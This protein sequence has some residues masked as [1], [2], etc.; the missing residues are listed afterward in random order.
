[1]HPESIPFGLRKKNITLPHKKIFFV[2]T[3][4]LKK[5]VFFAN[6]KTFLEYGQITVRYEN[7]TT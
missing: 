4:E 2:K 1:V 6:K 3:K 5:K 7:L